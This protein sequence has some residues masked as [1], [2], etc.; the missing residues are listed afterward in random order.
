V[1]STALL[2]V[3]VLALVDQDEVVAVLIAHLE[4]DSGAY[5]LK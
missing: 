3:K 5:S 1:G 4:N 2:S